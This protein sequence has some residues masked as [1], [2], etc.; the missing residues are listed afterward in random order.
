MFL[1]KLRAHYNYGTPFHENVSIA[2]EF[3]RYFASVYTIDNKILPAL[4]SLTKDVKLS[5]IYFNGISV[6]RAIKSLKNS[7]S[8][9][10][11]KIPN[12]YLKNTIASIKYSQ[13]LLFEKSFITN[14]IR[15][16]WKIATIIP[17]HKKGAINCVSNF[18]PMS[19]TSFFS[20]FKKR[21][22][23]NQLNNCLY[24]NHIISPYQCGF[25]RN[26]ST[27]HQLIDLHY[28]WVIQQSGDWLTDVILFD[29]SK[30]FDS[31]VHTKLFIKLS[32]Y[33]IHSALLL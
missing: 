19:L 33:G 17:I 32:A 12:F 20:K 8:S 14:F 28:D 26:S 30:A 18:R 16:I 5:I 24:S 10:P 22:I 29:Y 2:Q 9:G 7:M 27:V 31:I 13:S 11:D 4:P 23:V 1:I 15:E 25:R 6:S 3:N 21:V